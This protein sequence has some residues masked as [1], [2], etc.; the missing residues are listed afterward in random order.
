MKGRG[1]ETSPKDDEKKVGKSPVHVA[2]AHAGAL[3]EGE[4]LKEQLSSEFN[5]VELWLTDFSPV[6]GYA[7]GTGVLAIAFYTDN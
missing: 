1:S 3:N 4:R 6:M 5:C 7:T 2:G